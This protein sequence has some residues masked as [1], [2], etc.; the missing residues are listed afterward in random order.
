MIIP[1]RRNQT[2]RR[3]TSPSATSCSANLSGSNRVLRDER[4]ATVR[5]SRG[6]R[7]CVL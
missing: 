6:L 2:T 3:E 4:L 5:L 7:V 1:T